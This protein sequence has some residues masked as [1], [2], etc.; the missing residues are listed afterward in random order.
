VGFDGRK[1]KEVFAKSAPGAR[2]QLVGTLSLLREVFVVECRWPR[3]CSQCV[4][5]C[6]AVH[7]K[8]PC[9]SGRTCPRLS[10]VARAYRIQVGAARRSARPRPRL[11][12]HRPA[13]HDGKHD[14]LPRASCASWSP[15]PCATTM[16]SVASSPSASHSPCRRDRQART[17]STFEEE[18]FCPVRKNSVRLRNSHTLS[19]VRG[20]TKQVCPGVNNVGGEDAG[21]GRKGSRGG[22]ATRRK[23]G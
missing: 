6:Q 3:Q 8:L 10:T 20:S 15:I 16:A 7:E 1:V 21:A 11:Y 2:V 12:A 13:T 5:L 22:R 18:A 23:I 19:D 14:H 9:A 17:A 4:G